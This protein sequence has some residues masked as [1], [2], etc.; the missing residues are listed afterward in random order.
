MIVEWSELNSILKKKKKGAP[1]NFARNGGIS[2]GKKIST[3]K[4]RWQLVPCSKARALA[5]PGVKQRALESWTQCVDY[6][7][8]LRSGFQTIPRGLRAAGHRRLAPWAAWTPPLNSGLSTDRPLFFL[9]EWFSSSGL[10]PFT[11]GREDSNTCLTGFSGLNP[12]A[13]QKQLIVFLMF[14][15][16]LWNRKRGQNSC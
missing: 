13:L 8:T 6:S 12:T 4:S 9:G 14:F 7:L 15:Y 5:S 10:T 11:C 16:C 1:R 2:H 3:V